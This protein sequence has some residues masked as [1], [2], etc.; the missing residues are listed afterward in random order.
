MYIQKNSITPVISE[1][2]IAS[3]H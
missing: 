2:S 1:L 3:Y